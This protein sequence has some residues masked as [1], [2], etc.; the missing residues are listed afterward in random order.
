MKTITVPTYEQVS[1]A[2]QAIFRIQ[3]AVCQV[4]GR[5]GGGVGAGGGLR[6]CSVWTALALLFTAGRQGTRPGAF[7]LP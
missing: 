6:R 2:N 4:G 1:P 7:P 3:S 5:L